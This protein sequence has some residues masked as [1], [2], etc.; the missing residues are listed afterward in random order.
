VANG[1]AW[2]RCVQARLPA[3]ADHLAKI[4]NDA[5]GAL[6]PSM[7]EPERSESSSG[8]S[9]ST[10][11]GKAWKKM[12]RKKPLASVKRT[13]EGARVDILFKPKSDE[14]VF[15]RSCV[16]RVD[17]GGLRIVIRGHR[18]GLSDFRLENYENYGGAPRGPRRAGRPRGSLLLVPAEYLLARGE[19]WRVTKGGAVTIK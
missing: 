14:V 3:G 4:V 19:T 8:K 1:S 15:Q 6:D 2:V 18:V 10:A 13:K 16:Q 9:K 17:R 12:S 5:T 11:L 7:P